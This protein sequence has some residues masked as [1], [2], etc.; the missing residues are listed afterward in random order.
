MACKG[1]KATTQFWEVDFTSNFHN[2]NIESKERLFSLSPEST[3][4]VKRNY[5]I[6]KEICMQPFATGACSSTCLK[7]LNG[8]DWK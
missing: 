8:L 3:K 2:Q 4:K 1:L 7:N 6:P 5:N